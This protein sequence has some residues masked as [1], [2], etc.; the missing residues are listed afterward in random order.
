[1]VAKGE[2]EGQA[3]SSQ[4][5]CGPVVFRRQLRLEPS[6]FLWAMANCGISPPF[7]FSLSSRARA[8]VPA[9]VATQTAAVATQDS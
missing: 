6:G 3:L 7:F 5:Q 4:S 9:A 8:Q 1:M 2:G